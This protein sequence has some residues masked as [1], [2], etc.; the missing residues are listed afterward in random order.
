MKDE[1]IKIIY[2]G[3]IIE[4]DFYLAVKIR[5]ALDEAIKEYVKFKSIK[6]SFDEKEKSPRDSIMR[7]SFPY[8]LDV[9][10]YHCHIES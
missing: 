1:K 6:F 10:K 9:N 7:N 2:R 4:I 5:I 3:E 8:L